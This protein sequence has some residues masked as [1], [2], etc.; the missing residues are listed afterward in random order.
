M[1]TFVFCLLLICLNSWSAGAQPVTNTSDLIGQL[2][3]LV[4][5][6]DFF[7]LRDAYKLDKERLPKAYEMYFGSI[8]ETVFN[9]PSKSN[10]LITD[11]LKADPQPLSPDWLKRIYSIKLQNHIDLFEYA[12][13]ENTNRFIVATYA[14]LLDSTEV[15]EYRNSQK[16][17]HALK[18]AP[19][20]EIIRTGDFYGK[21][22]R[23]KMGLLRINTQIGDDSLSMIFDTGANFSVMQRS[24]AERLGLKILNTQFEV[25]AATGQK[26]KSDLAVAPE[27]SFGGIHLK[28]VVFLVFNDQDLSFPQI[29]YHI[30]GIIGFP[31]IKAMEEIQI[32]KDNNLHVPQNP[33]RYDNAN[34]ALDGLMPVVAVKY[35]G[36]Q[37]CFHFDTGA[38]HTSLFPPFYQKYQSEIDR[39]YKRENLHAGSAGGE[40]TFEGYTIRKLP[41]EIAGA[42]AT[43]KKIRL[44]VNKTG[45]GD[46][47][48]GNLGQ[49]Y[50]QQ[51]R[52]F[53]ISFKDAAIRFR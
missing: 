48:Y 33:G 45:V 13:A 14:D 8:L 3:E 11:L 27:I 36:E 9:H 37:L 4:K 30:E 20:Q 21:L 12:K 41:I 44:N 51:F 24:V 53:V 5:Q 28:N 26:V 38:T 2:Q 19:K 29:D 35:R 52:E 39:K 25:T 42:K 17:W 43:L 47:F 23:D 18:D 34:F 50:I 49:D 16:I 7:A 32:D 40:T 6:K 31:V 15:E 22:N 10:E 46:D 1:R